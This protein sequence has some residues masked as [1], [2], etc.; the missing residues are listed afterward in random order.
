[1]GRSLPTVLRE[2]LFVSIRDL[3][4][5][6]SWSL[7]ASLREILLVPI[8][9]NKPSHLYS[10]CRPQSFNFLP[11]LSNTSDRASNRSIPL[12]NRIS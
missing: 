2:I 12:S 4:R 3:I 9:A 10:L 5:G 11:T 6:H 7:F 8:Y 1:M